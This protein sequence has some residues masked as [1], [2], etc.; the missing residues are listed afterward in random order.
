MK[1]RYQFCSCGLGVLENNYL[2]LFFIVTAKKQRRR[3]HA[4]QLISAILNWGK[5]K[6]A[7]Q[8]YIQVETNN[9]K[10]I[11]LYNTLGFTEVY[12]YYYRTKLLSH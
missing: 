9:L 7:T 12:Q 3:G 11:N 6:G 8:A 4:N 2:G 5:S 10:A 1:H